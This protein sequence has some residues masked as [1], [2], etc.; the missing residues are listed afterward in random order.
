M[1]ADLLMA[2]VVTRDGYW[3]GQ[4]PRVGDVIEVPESFVEA[5]TRD[6]FAVVQDQ[7]A[8]PPPPKK[9]GSPHGR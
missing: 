7:P 1:P 3:N 9:K 8:A 6:G 2:M 4:Y 5:L